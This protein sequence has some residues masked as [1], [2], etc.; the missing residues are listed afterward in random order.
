MILIICS[1]C[2]SWAEVEISQSN[3]PS[4]PVS[5]SNQ[6]PFSSCNE[7]NLPLDIKDID[8]DSP[9]KDHPDYR[10]M[11]F[12]ASL[13]E[14]LDPCFRK[15][16]RYGIEFAMNTGGNLAFGMVGYGYYYEYGA[17]G[18][19]TII[20]GENDSQ[21]YSPGIFVGGRY[22]LCIR[23]ILACGI[24]FA[25]NFG[26]K[27]DRDI[28]KDLITSA[29]I[30][31][32]QILSRHVLLS[33]WINPYQFEYQKLEGLKPLNVHSICSSGGIAIAYLFN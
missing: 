23:T 25:A 9:D 21:I 4:S 22:H 2:L 32:E 28:Q 6:N 26:K 20:D 10:T 5:S 15:R 19:I 29:Y 11:Y 33:F 3:N 27:D 30:S 1:A 18:S 13:K 14:I 7:L 31:F 12:E 16:F 24:D 17:V 8:K